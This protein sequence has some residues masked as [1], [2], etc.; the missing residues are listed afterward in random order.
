MHNCY[1]LNLQSSFYDFAIGCM[2]ILAMTFYIIYNECGSCH[3]ATMVIAVRAHCNPLE[4]YV[5]MV[6][7]SDDIIYYDL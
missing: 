4:I 5:L 6:I 3:R 2:Y 1:I 7:E